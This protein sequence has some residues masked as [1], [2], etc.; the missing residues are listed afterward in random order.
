[1]TSLNSPSPRRFYLWQGGPSLSQQTLGEAGGYLLVGGVCTAFDISLLMGLVHFG[2][3]HYL[4]AGAISFL[5][6]T[7][8]NYLLCTLWL[9]R[10]RRVKYRPLEFLAY[11]TITGVGLGCNVGLL[12]FFTERF[13]WHFALSKLAATAL[14][15]VWNFSSRKI[16]L[17]R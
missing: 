14:V 16:L 5:A 9:F 2:K 10:V 6:A 13:G 8:L 11:L 7:L 17:H 1:M 15:V 12:W 3:L 4:V